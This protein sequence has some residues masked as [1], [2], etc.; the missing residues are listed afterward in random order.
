MNQIRSGPGRIFGFRSS[1]GRTRVEFVAFIL[2]RVN[3]VFVW[4][5]RIFKFHN[6]PGLAQVEILAFIPGRINKDFVQTRLAQ[7]WNFRLMQ[8]S[9]LYY[10]P[11]NSC[12]RPCWYRPYQDYTDVNLFFHIIITN[13]D[14]S[15]E[16]PPVMIR[17]YLLAESSYLVMEKNSSLCM[18]RTAELFI[19]ARVTTLY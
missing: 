6:G 11:H 16:C 18:R 10:R 19:L 15:F 7:D 1:P 5:G 12:T 3:K 4:L 2:G 13:H 17:W 8:T 14:Y 9:N